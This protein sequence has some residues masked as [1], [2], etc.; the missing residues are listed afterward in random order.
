MKRYK[1]NLTLEISYYVGRKVLY[2][3]DYP[4]EYPAQRLAGM[5]ELAEMILL[6]LCTKRTHKEKMLQEIDA[7]DSNPVNGE[8]ARVWAYAKTFIHRIFK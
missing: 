5:E 4:D 8:F 3:H 6:R 7:Y 2:H 1:H